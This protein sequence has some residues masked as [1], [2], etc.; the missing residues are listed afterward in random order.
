MYSTSLLLTERDCDSSLEMATRDLDTYNYRIT[1]IGYR[2]N[3]SYRSAAEAQEDIL[4]V[5]AEIETINATI[6]ALPEGPAKEDQITKLMRK[7][8]QLRT[9]NG[10]SGASDAV[11]T[12]DQELELARLNLGRT[13]TQGFIDAVNARK[14]EILAAVD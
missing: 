9:L 2:R 14:T 8:L 1:T 10:R 7:E 4:I 6:A 11:N 12:L 5:Q 3:N 13:E